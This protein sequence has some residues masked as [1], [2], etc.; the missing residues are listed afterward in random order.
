MFVKSDNKALQISPLNEIKGGET[1]CDGSAVFKGLK[2]S[3]YRPPPPHSKAGVDSTYMGYKM[4]SECSPTQF[5]GN[6]HTRPCQYWN[7]Q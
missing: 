5:G 3:Y 2:R 7:N 4:T 6:S 1:G